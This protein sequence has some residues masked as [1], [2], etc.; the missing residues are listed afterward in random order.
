MS[1]LFGVY[2]AWG[3]LNW[4][5]NEVERV[6]WTAMDAAPTEPPPSNSHEWCRMP[7]LDTERK[8][9]ITI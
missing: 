8:V 3:L 5:R 2:I 7:Q 9:T 6:V 1:S 4:D